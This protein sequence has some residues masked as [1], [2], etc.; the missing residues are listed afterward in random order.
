M[1]FTNI[2]EHSSVIQLIQ[3]AL[4]EDI[5]TGDI[6]TICTISPDDYQSAI[7]L[8]KQDGIIAGLPLIPII[9][10]YLDTSAR[11]EWLPTAQD[12][13][14]ISKGTICG[15]CY[16]RTNLLLPAERT[17][18][19]FLQRLSGIA[20]TTQLYVQA[21]SGTTT[22]ICD[23]RKT[24]PGWRLL[25]KYAVSMG[26]GTNHRMGL[27][28]M[29]MVKDNHRDAAGSLTN[30]IRFVHETL[31]NQSHI[32]VE[33]ETRTLDDVH[34]VM[35]CFRAGLRVNRI[36]FDNFTAGDVEKALNI[37]EGGLITE[38]SGGI[39]LHNILSFAQTGVDFISV[40]AL[41]HSAPAM[42]ISMKIQPSL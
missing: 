17:I 3:G 4:N 35:Q 2:F 7:I 33:V 38:V 18:L 32:P 37:V 15:R 29:V 22:K 39:T 34:E 42:D 9:F 13:D 5:G 27:Y 10:H 36:M 24:L 6:T 40:G 14:Y 20:T 19:N 11:I 8:A 23:T 30:A 41:T 31:Q 21:V 26:G 16:A 12:G 28:D 1:D 25:D